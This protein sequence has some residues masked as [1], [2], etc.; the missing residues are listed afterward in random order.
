VQ[1]EDAHIDLAPEGAFL[2]DNEGPRAQDLSF[3]AAIEANFPFPKIQGT[4][5]G[6]PLAD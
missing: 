5:D 6:D 4:D 1:H 2:P 3:Q